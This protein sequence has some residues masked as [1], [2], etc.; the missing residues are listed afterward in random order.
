MTAESFKLR[1]VLVAVVLVIAAIVIPLVILKFGPLKYD[2]SNYSF[3]VTLTPQQTDTRWFI[4][5]KGYTVSGTYSVSDGNPVQIT[6]FYQTSETS[7]PNSIYN[8]VVSSGSFSFKADGHALGGKYYLSSYN[9]ASAGFFGLGA[10]PT[11]TVTVTFKV[12]GW[13]TFL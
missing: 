11:I 8:N 1:R 3:T 6:V 5:P 9:P 13:T 2:E 4:V 10:G 12:S 7:F